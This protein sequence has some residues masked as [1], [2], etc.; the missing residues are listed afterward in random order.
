MSGMLAKYSAPIQSITGAIQSGATVSVFTNGSTN[1]GTQQGTLTT[2]PLYPA[3]SL[4]APMTNPFVLAGGTI[5]F[6]LPFP[7]RVDLGI[8]LPGTAPVYFADIDVLTAGIVPT[9]VTSSYTLVLSDQLLLASAAAGNVSLQLPVSWPGLVYRFKRT[10]NSGNSMSVLAAVGQQIDGS[11]SLGL[12]NL[13]R[14]TLIG[15]GS[16]WWSV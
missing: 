5:T 7:Q 14:A 10:D 16:N 6:Y 3:A 8:Q 4:I 1:G 12:T 15:D 9:V 13:A 11:A 2:V